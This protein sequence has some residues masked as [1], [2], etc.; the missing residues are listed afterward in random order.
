MVPIGE[1]AKFS[2]E[3][4][5]SMARLDSGEANGGDQDMVLHRASLFHSLHVKR[6]RPRENAEVS[7][8]F[9]LCDGR[10]RDNEG[11]LRSPEFACVVE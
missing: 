3:V 9:S 7:V 10:Q 8:L 5:G 6:S 2:G 11:G 1:C 4:H